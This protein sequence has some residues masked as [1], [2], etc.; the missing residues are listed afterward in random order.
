MNCSY[1]QLISLEELFQAWTD[2]RQGKGKKFDVR[3]FER[4]L[5]DNLFSLHKKLKNKTYEHGDY[6]DF[7]VNDPK[8][9]HIHKA[10]VSDRIV[11][12]LLYRYLYQLFDKTFIYDS[13]SCRLNKGTHKAVKRLEKFVRIAS[14]NYSRDCWALKCDIKKFFDSI[15]HKILFS[16]ISK[17]SKDQRILWLIKEVIDSFRSGVDLEV[18]PLK[19]IPLGNLTSQIF[20][21]IYLNELDQFIKQEVKARYYLRYAD[22][23]IILD[24]NRTHLYQY[25]NTL[26]QF[27]ETDLKLEL[28]P[29]KVVFRKLN[30]GIDFCGYRMFPR[31][32]LVTTKTKKRIFKKVIKTDISHQSLQSYLG[33]F[34]HANSYK[35][36][37][38]LK[39]FFFFTSKF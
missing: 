28:H 21:N 38:D 18:E 6:V 16:L 23:F 12:H 37:Q 20:A 25:V 34:S 13:Y 9:R 27:L 5:E 11:H 14:Y 36:M 33:H 26:K 15:D 7:Y 22:D 39:D 19:G 31:Y 1:Q 17:K 35:N 24:S 8:R 32:K 4:H 29:Q 30:W 10:S 2:F 3:L